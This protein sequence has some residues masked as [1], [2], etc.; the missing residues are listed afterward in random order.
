MI[1]I[2]IAFDLQSLK[3]PANAGGFFISLRHGKRKP[4]IWDTRNY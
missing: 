2:N 1:I 3:P 4:H